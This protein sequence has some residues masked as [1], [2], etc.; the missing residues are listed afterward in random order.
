MA[1]QRCLPVETISLPTPFGVGQVNAF[2]IVAEPMTM[3]DA[4][5]N[6]LGAENALKLGFAGKGLFLEAVERILL[7][8]GH[9]DHSGLVP[10][11]C[12][13]NGTGAAK[14]Y[15]GEQEVKSIEDAGAPWEAGRQLSQA[16]FPDRLIKE[17][18]KMERRLHRVHRVA[19]LDCLPITQGQVFKFRDFALETVPLPGDTEGHLGFLEPESKALFAGDALLPHVYRNLSIKPVLEP[20]PE[21]PRRRRNSLQQHLAT[22]DKIQSMNLSCV[23]PGHGPAITDPTEAVVFLQRRHARR[24]DQVCDALPAGSSTAFDASV[25]MYPSAQGYSRLLAVWE[26]VAHLHVLVERSRIRH[27]IREDGV[28]YFSRIVSPS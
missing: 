21:S 18:A 24:L 12:N 22:L 17:L 19:Q 7:T 4:G 9:P 14:A 16:G 23:Y 10:L 26:T 6:T 11:I 20:E 28:E 27:E 8:H 3:V 13:G 5:V 1:L 25:V 15:M 2:V